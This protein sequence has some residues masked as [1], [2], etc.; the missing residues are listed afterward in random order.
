M[1]GAWGGVDC[2][3]AAVGAADGRLVV[4]LRG[5][6]V[7]LRARI[8][9]DVPILHAGLYEDVDTRAEADGRAWWPMASDAEGNPFRALVTLPW[10]PD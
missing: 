2:S 10:V 7:A 5:R 1:G 9:S 6:A 8:E 3:P 4:V